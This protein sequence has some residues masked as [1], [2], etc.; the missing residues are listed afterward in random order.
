MDGR[1]LSRAMIVDYDLVVAQLATRAEELTDF[2]G[3]FVETIYPEMLQARQHQIIYGRRGTGKTHLLKRLEARLRETFA[4]TRILPIYVNGS[5]LTHE[6]RT[7]SSDPVTVATAIYVQLMQHITGAIRAFVA[8]LNQAN[9]WDRV[10]AGGKSHPERQATTIAAELAETLISGQVRRLPSGEVLDEATT[11][12]ETSSKSG[13]E[14]SVRADPRTLGWALKAGTASE[15][16]A[17]SSSTSTRKTHGEVI[18][19]F[20]YV[21]SR[22]ESLLELLNEASIHILFDEWSDI[23]KDQQ[24]QPYLAEMLRKTTSAVPGMFLKLACIP[25]RTSLATPIT[26]NIRNP[27][28]LEEGDDIHA[29]VNLDQIVFSGNSLAEVVPFFMAMIK[30]HVGEKIDWVRHASPTYFDTFLTT[31][32]FDGKKPF[33]ELCHASGGVPRDFINIYRRATALISG[34]A[35]AGQDRRPL[36]VLKVR[37]AAKTIYES[38]RASFGARSGSPQ[39]ELLDEIYR[40]I[41]VKKGSWHFLLSEERAESDDIQMLF[42]EKLIHRLPLNF[43]NSADDRRYEYFQL[44]YGTAIDRLMSDAADGAAA[45]YE[46]SAW[47]Q[48]GERGGKFLSRALDDEVSRQRVA[49]EA[50]I[51]ALDEAEPGRL[52]IKPRELIFPPGGKADASSRARKLRPQGRHRR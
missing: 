44:D 28:G 17:R 22:L 26:D 43:Y 7:V 37:I 15:R 29:D 2:Y 10:V 49:Y 40:A 27:I 12:L 33:L 35:Q 36:D 48:L 50:I 42:T 38:K 30:K 31:I 4:E 6:I 41:Y 20:S 47:A 39:L 32:I 8:E 1:P 16:N 5:H 11:L 14:A 52:D 9:V 34:S 21:S 51:T 24:V 23:D 45:S 13:I 19:P 25:G 18:L 46:N 3:T